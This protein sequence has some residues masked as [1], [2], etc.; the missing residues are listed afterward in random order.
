MLIIGQL[1]TTNLERN[2]RPS[3]RFLVQPG[4]TVS[5]LTGLTILEADEGWTA[6]DRHEARV[7]ARRPHSPPRRAKR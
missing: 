3:R 6:E 4:E 2:P 5:T 7:V 1:T